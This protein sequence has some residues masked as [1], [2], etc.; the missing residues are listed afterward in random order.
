MVE[1][2]F[3]KDGYGKVDGAQ[4]TTGFPVWLRQRVHVR[5]I[6]QKLEYLVTIIQDAS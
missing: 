4:K 2:V 3:Q 1:A 5:N 6:R